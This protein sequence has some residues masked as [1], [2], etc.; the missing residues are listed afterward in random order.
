MDVDDEVSLACAITDTKAGDDELIEP[1]AGQAQANLPQGRIETLAYDKAAG[2]A[3]AHEALHEH[4]IKPVVQMRAS[5]KGEKE[6][7]LRVGLP[8]VYDEAG[9]VS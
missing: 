4:G 8:L 2:D 9:T 1:L 7:P 3:K 6:K 5:W